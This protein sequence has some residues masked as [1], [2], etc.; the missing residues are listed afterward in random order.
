VFIGFTPSEEFLCLSQKCSYL[1]T[2]AKRQGRAENFYETDNICKSD[3]SYGDDFIWNISRSS[4]SVDLNLF[5]S[6]SSLSLYHSVYYIGS[7][8]GVSSGSLLF[9]R[10][11]RRRAAAIGAGLMTISTLCTTFATSYT[12]LLALRILQGVGD[13]LGYLG[14][15]VW[16]FE[17]TPSR[18]RLIYNTLIA[19]LWTL[20]YPILSC[21]SYYIHNWRYI[22][23]A[24]GLVQGFCQIPLLFC[25]DSPRYLISIGRSKQASSILQRWAKLGDID[26]NLE[27]V[28]LI[29]GTDENENEKLKVKIPVLQ[30]LLEFKKYPA[31]L[32]ETVSM[33]WITMVTG[34]L[35]NG[36]AY[37]W[38]RFDDSLYVLYL[39]VGV[40]E[41]IAN[42]S[43][44]F[45]LKMIGRKVALVSFSASGK[46]FVSQKL[47]CWKTD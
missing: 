30:Q 29:E 47:L 19:N 14:A 17:M 42:S 24:V 40:G 28:E 9:E 20:G 23:V 26:I 13:Q 22:C 3:L 37:G 1:L 32:I 33:T 39:Y 15:Y 2:E 34:F 25:P 18:Y 41:V 7:L 11:G 45:V 5:C 46:S 43:V 38:D 16:L 12:I 27:G 8:L 4:F 6:S 44:L 35:F 31:M 36:L 21:I 10:I